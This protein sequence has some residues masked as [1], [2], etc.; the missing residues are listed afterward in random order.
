M[1]DTTSYTTFPFGT[2]FG[3][4]K[5]YSL[6]ITNRKFR[7]SIA[8]NIQGQWDFK[9]QTGINC[10]HDDLLRI[11]LA[12]QDI[13]RIYILN[14]GGGDHKAL[15]GRFRITLSDP[16]LIDTRKIQIPL[17]AKS[18][19]IEYG[20]F[21]VGYSDSEERGLKK[22]AFYFAYSYQK[23]GDDG[24]TVNDHFVFKQTLGSSGELKYLQA[25]GTVLHHSPNEHLMFSNF[26]QNLRSLYNSGKFFYEQLAQS[27]YSTRKGTKTQGYTSD[28]H[29]ESNA[30]RDF[31]DIPF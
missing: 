23:Q 31:D 13:A 18:T 15:E 4:T 24:G 10:D 27:T 14:N 3:D 29:E 7:I 19:G 1:A 28:S 8:S 5:A 26:I 21:V 17:V 16:L 6:S 20:K 12:T 2:V 11:L 25:D 22:G 30:S 9:R